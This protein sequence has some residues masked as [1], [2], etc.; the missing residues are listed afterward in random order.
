MSNPWDPLPFPKHGDS[1]E[2]LTYQHV[3]RL[4]SLWEDIEFGFCRIHSV[5]LGDPDGQALRLYGA[6]RAFLA[7]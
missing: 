1:T 2:N 6:R 3:G 5:F 4:V 7:V